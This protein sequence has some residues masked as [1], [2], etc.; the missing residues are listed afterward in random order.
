M[1][2]FTYPVSATL[3]FFSVFIDMAIYIVFAQVIF[4]YV[5]HVA[6]FSRDQLFLVVGSSMLIEWMSWFTFRPGTGQLPDII[7]SGKIEVAFLRP[8]PSQFSATFT[9]MDIEDV[10]RVATALIVIIPHISAIPSPIILHVGA[11]IVALLAGLII[12]FAF[13]SSLGS[14]GFF[15]GRMDGM[16]AILN[17]IN[18]V[19]RYPHTIF[20]RKVQWIFFTMLP[21][22]FIGSIPTLVL[23]STHWLWWL[24]L[25]LGAATV[26]FYVST[27]FW[28]WAASHYSGASG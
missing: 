23:T 22:A 10:T 1:T 14:L 20:S 27:L 2:R 4:S 13:L 6:G 18:S 9:R 19:S 15:F 5:P 7:R 3:N 24:L 16:W 8:L 11:Y 17:E 28:N 21:T 25:M 26:F 12:L